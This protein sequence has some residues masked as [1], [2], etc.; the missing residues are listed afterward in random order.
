MRSSPPKAVE[1]NG[2]AQAC[3]P[4]DH[5]YNVTSYADSHKGV[6]AG[7]SNYNGTSRKA[8]MT[9]TATVSGTVSL[10]HN[11]TITV[12]AA[13]LIAGGELAAG[14]NLSASLT[15]SLG[16]TVTVEAPPRTTINAVYGI[17]R[18]KTIGQY[19]ICGGSSQ[20]VT[21]YTPWKVGWH[22]TQQRER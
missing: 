15:A 1:D 13:K 9:F 16:N 7:Q 6:G 17:W 5:S 10:T 12:K 20:T 4:G 22:L 11:A 14:V 19:A 2:F 3:R 18:K 8:I 21:A